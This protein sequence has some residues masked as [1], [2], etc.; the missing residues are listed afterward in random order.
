MVAQVAPHPPQDLQRVQLDALAVPLRKRSLFLLHCMCFTE[1]GHSSPEPPIFLTV[2]RVKL[3]TTFSYRRESVSPSLAMQP[4]TSSS[5]CL[6]L[7]VCCGRYCLLL[8]TRA[9][10]TLQPCY[11]EKLIIGSTMQQARALGQLV[12]SM[13][14]WLTS[15]LVSLK[16]LL[17]EKMETPV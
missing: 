15:Y 5:S 3:G 12:M 1:V 14:H 9:P 11:A 7:G 8:R 13:G 10:K 4:L 2:I 16:K 17:L 6:E